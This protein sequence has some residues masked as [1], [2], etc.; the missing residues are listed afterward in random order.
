MGL[1]AGKPTF[2]FDNSAPGTPIPNASPSW[3]EVTDATILS[4]LRSLGT[5][6]TNVSGAVTAFLPQ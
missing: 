6:V 3:T 4:L 1:A 5:M 2:Y